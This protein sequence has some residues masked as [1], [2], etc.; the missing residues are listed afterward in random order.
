MLQS[1]TDTTLIYI[2]LLVT[3]CSAA[4]LLL[5]V[6]LT[7]HLFNVAAQHTLPRHHLPAILTVTRLLLASHTSM[8]NFTIMLMQII[9]CVIL[10]IVTLH[11]SQHGM[12]KSTLE[13]AHIIHWTTLMWCSVHKQYFIIDGSCC[14]AATYYIQTIL[15][16]PAV[17]AQH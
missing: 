12:L 15:T 3:T 11:T 10:V 6:P 1:I 14:C 17:T 16:H 2:L 7:L 8:L 5:R 4:R 9:I 13:F